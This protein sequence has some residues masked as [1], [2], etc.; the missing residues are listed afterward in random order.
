MPA[1]SG[2]SSRSRL[3]NVLPECE[4]TL[5]DS[6]V[7]RRPVRSRDSQAG[8]LESA[9]VWLVEAGSCAET[10]AHAH[11]ISGVPKINRD[12]SPLWQAIRKLAFSGAQPHVGNQKQIE[13]QKPDL[14]T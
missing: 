11:E 2:A 14:I 7:S 4:E 5:T 13:K 10:C 1:G 12:S 6:S 3:A 8:V 9:D